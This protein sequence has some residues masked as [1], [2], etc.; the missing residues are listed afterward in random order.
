MARKCSTFQLKLLT[1]QTSFNLDIKI[2][3]LYDNAEMLCF[4]NFVVLTLFTVLSWKVII[5][6]TKRRLLK[7]SQV[8][9]FFSLW[10][11][12]INYCH[13][14][15]PDCKIKIASGFFSYKLSSSLRKYWIAHFKHVMECVTVQ[16]LQD[17]FKLSNQLVWLVDVDS[18]SVV[19]VCVCVCLLK[20]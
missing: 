12:I 20:R 18:D 13:L 17:N 3:E 16:T 5:I 6:M 7:L 9:F 11:N 4:L 8:S 14:I 1:Q 10:I 2:G 15:A 19:C